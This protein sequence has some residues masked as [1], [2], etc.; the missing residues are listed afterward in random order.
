MHHVAVDRL[1]IS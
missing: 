1:N